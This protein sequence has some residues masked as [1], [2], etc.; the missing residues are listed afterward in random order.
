VGTPSTYCAVPGIPPELID[1]KAEV[2]VLS[3]LLRHGRALF[4]ALAA[5]ARTPPE[6]GF[7]TAD[8]RGRAWELFAFV[9]FGRP[10]GP[11]L[12]DCQK[13][14][15]K[16]REWF[17]FPCRGDALVWIADLWTADVWLADMPQW[18]GP[19]GPADYRMFSAAAVAGRDALSPVAGAGHYVK[20]IDRITPEDYDDG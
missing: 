6:R 16:R 4:E 1:L 19:E 15:W 7:F 18:T 20:R 12:V 10:A 11:I 8:A 9:A 3:G 13:E 17:D 2:A 14:M 5:A